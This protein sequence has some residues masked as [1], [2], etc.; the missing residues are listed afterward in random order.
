MKIIVLFVTMVV[1]FCSS[2]C[3]A[4]ESKFKDASY[5]F[6]NLKSIGLCYIGYERV[7]T[8]GTRNFVQYKNPEP[9]VLEYL[10]KRPNAKVVTGQADKT[11]ASLIVEIY[12]IGVDEN[13][14]TRAEMEFI[15]TDR[16]SGDIVYRRRFD[17]TDTISCPELL[18]SICNDFYKDIVF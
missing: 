17:R 8:D 2:V 6:R 18:A 16:D 4:M 12:R 15:L 7:F 5:D 11:P 1:V 13:D 14:L 3:F 10:V 9:D